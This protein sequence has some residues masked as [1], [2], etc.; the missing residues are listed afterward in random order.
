MVEAGDGL[1]PFGVRVAQ[2]I[3]DADRSASEI[4][5]DAARLNLRDQDGGIPGLPLGKVVDLTR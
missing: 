4:N 1:E 5:A 3:P 2:R